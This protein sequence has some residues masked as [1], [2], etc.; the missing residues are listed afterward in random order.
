M[1]AKDWSGEFR[2]SLWLQIAGAP[3]V[4]IPR[5]RTLRLRELGRAPQLPNPDPRPSTVA[6]RARSRPGS[7]RVWI[8]LHRG[9]E[10]VAADVATPRIVAGRDSSG[11]PGRKAMMD[12]I[13]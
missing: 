9:S 10:A 2:V 1:P 6:F 4:Y 7:W 11:E 12:A 8:A 5:I 3:S 13:M